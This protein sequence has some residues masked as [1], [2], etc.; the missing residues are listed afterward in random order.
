MTM[1]KM[2]SLHVN[3]CGAD[4]ITTG[5]GLCRYVAEHYDIPFIHNKETA[6][7]YN[8]TY[9]VLF[10]KF[11]ILLFCNYREELFD[12]Y[13]KAKRIVSLEEDYTM[14]ADYRLLKLNPEYDLVSNMP[15]RAEEMGGEY[16]NWNR[17]TWENDVAMQDPILKGLGYYGSY[18]P[19]RAKYFE[20]YFK[21]APYQ[22]SIS[23]F[24]RNALKFKDIDKKVNVFD[25][26]KNRDKIRAFKSVLIVEDVFTHTH[27]NSPP[28]RF[29]E[30]LS[31]GVPMLFD[32]NTT[33]TYEEAGYDIG[34]YT[35][36]C[37]VEVED[38]LQIIES[39]RAEQRKE[40]F[41][42]YRAEFDKDF[43]DVMANLK[44]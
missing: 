29:Y 17:L 12:I 9:D 16:L 41:R 3:S 18:R 40:W 38:C 42:D 20:H 5:V 7:A 4:S 6:M 23:T 8:D 33:N 34:S 21:D 1:L 28:N 13:K 24:G 32:V 26:F 10:V 43:I 44:L 15:F 31:R 14:D 11:G 37:Q 30:C 25:P 36:A 35:V 39:I 2:A 19:D 22:V 27:Y